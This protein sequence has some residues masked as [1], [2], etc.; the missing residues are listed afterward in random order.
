LEGRHQLKTKGEAFRDRD[1]GCS[2]VNGLRKKS[3][4]TGAKAYRGETT[5][6]PLALKKG[7]RREK[8]LREE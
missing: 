2:N 1:R 6:S 8:G 3:E 5:S 7:S 4:T